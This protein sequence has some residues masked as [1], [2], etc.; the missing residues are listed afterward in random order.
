V[1][2]PEFNATMAI[3]LAIVVTTLDF[4][5]SNS[6][7]H[8]RRRAQ[9]ARINFSTPGSPYVELAKHRD[10]HYGFAHF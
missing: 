5:F 8:P 6:Q 10:V 9:T 3:L 4:S 2:A 7:P 1:I